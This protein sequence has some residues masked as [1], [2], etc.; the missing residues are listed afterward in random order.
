MHHAGS[1]PRNVARGKDHRWRGSSRW[2]AAASREVPSRRPIPT[3]LSACPAQ[4]G[5]TPDRPR[6]VHHRRQDRCAQCQLHGYKT[7][8]AHF[9]EGGSRLPHQD[10][11]RLQEALQPTRPL[12]KPHASLMRRRFQSWRKDH[13]NAR[14]PPGKA[15][16]QIGIFGHVPSIPVASLDETVAIEMIAGPTQRNRKT[17]T[18][19]RWQDAAKLD[20]V[21]QC[22]LRRQPT[23][24]IRQAHERRLNAGQ[25]R[26]PAGKGGDRRF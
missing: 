3:L 9:S 21:F 17:E 1:S 25:V 11:L 5:Q 8:K 24:V 16:S 20:R 10:E 7:S 18:R 19:Q 26:R 6:P 14:P 15:R 2:I 4:P 13:A 12:R 23:T 22:P